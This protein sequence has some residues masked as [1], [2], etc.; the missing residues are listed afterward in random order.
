MLVNVI[1]R[2]YVA[3]GGYSGVNLVVREMRGMYR[4]SEGDLP[5]DSVTHIEWGRSIA[6]LSQN[7]SYSGVE[8]TPKI[9]LP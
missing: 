9:V 6:F 1:E 7:T 5:D 8:L 3:S 4:Y 2:N